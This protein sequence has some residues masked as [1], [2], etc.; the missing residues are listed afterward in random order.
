[1]NH[2]LTWHSRDGKTA[3]PVDFPIVN[4]RLA[5]SIQYTRIYRSAVI[6]IKSNEHNLVVS[7]INL[8]LKFQK[9]YYLPGNHNVG[10]LQDQ[11]FRTLQEQLNNLRV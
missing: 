1:M 2:K 4:Q 8:K 3:H 9:G 7:R 10:R 5:G 6:N 11:N